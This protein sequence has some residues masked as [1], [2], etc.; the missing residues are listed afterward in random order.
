[1]THETEGRNK[2]TYETYEMKEE[3]IKALQQTEERYVHL[4]VVPHTDIFTFLSLS[5]THL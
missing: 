1:M 3:H 5:P 2:Q 4:T